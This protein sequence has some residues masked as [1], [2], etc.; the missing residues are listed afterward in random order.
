MELEV[1]GP[2]CLGGQ[3]AEFPAGRSIYGESGIESFWEKSSLNAQ[4]VTVGAGS[5]SEFLLGT[6]SL[7]DIR[8]D[9]TA[10]QEELFCLFC[11]VS[12]ETIALDNLPQPSGALDPPE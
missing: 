10:L 6:W 12:F 7:E 2:W 4:T 5:L 11:L 8:L 3:T 9:L 1:L